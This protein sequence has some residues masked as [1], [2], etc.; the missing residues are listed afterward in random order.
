MLVLGTFA[1]PCSAG[2]SE[3][4]EPFRVSGED[5]QPLELTFGVYT[6]DKPTDMVD[7]FRPLLN[8]LEAKLSGKLHRRVKIKMQIAPTYEE[9][10]SD[11]VEGRVDIARLGPASYVLAYQANPGITVL[12]MESI[13]GRKTFPG[14]ICVHRDSDISSIEMLRGR[15]FAF[16]SEQS[17]IG[18]YLAQQLLVDHGVHAE[19][20]AAWEYLGRHDRVGAAVAAGQFDAGALKD[21][22]FRRLVDRGEPVRVLA[23]MEVVTKPWLGRRGL[24]VLVKDAMRESL[25]E[26]DDQEA[27]NALQFDHFVVGTDADY[28]PI[29]RSIE[30]SRRFFER[31]EAVP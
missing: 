25:L 4:T 27:L 26:V 28:A 14:I 8:L 13:K 15:R 20:L 12:A 7:Q 6:S 17:T 11:L 5:S 24:P 31:P 19:D 3:D 21:S 23:T 29:R 9:G 16:G 22:S 2:E 30:S 18:R 10:V 1:V